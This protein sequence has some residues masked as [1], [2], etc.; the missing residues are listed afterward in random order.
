MWW[1]C[2]PI[3]E[4]QEIW[5]PRMSETELNKWSSLPNHV[6]SRGQPTGKTAHG[7]KSGEKARLDLLTGF[8]PHQKR[9][10]WNKRKNTFHQ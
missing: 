6:C 7:G 10:K 1:K 3:E 9:A 2:L 4:K 8:R 5:M